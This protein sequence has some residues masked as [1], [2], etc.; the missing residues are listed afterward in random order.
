MERRPGLC[1]SRCVARIY[2]RGWTRKLWRGL[3]ESPGRLGTGYERC[4][5]SPWT[6]SF[7]LGL[8]PDRG[9]ASG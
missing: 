7:S 6:R 3:T 5:A 9:L 8:A 4:A 1:L 2:K